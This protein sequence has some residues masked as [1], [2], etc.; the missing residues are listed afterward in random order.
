MV[1]MIWFSTMQVSV[2]SVVLK[3][4]GSIEIGVCVCVCVLFK[5]SVYGT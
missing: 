4:K 5:V 3:F 1:R 2:Y